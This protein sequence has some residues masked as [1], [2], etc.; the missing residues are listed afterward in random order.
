MV[1]KKIKGVTFKNNLSSQ[2]SNII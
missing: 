1:T 2:K